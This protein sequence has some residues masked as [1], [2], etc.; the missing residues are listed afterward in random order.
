MNF[1]EEIRNYRSIS[2][3]GLAKNVGKTVTLNHL[4]RTSREAS[5]DVGV[6]SIGID[7]EGKDLVTGTSKPEIRIYRDMLFA[8][9]ETHYRMRRIQSEIIGITSYHTSLGR[10][11]TAK[12]LSDGKAM[13][14]G[15]ADTARLKDIIDRMGYQEG[16]KRTVLVDGA[17]SRMSLASPTVTEAMVLATGAALSPDIRQITARTADVCMLINLPKTE[18]PLSCIPV[19][20]GMWGMDHE[21][22]FH[23]LG[24]KSALKTGVTR[25]NIFRY[26]TTFYVSGI[27]TDH[28]IKYLLARKEIESV[29]LIVKDFTR[30]FAA[31]ALIRIFLAKG[32][33]ICV[34]YRSK[35]IAVTVNPYSPAGY[36]VDREKLVES[37]QEKLNV[38][39]TYINPES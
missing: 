30:I 38:P 23:D 31:P 20:E 32:G 11:V 10:V 35:L 2:V 21:G 37:L 5:L 1:A 24:L 16:I 25:T 13:L 28:L 8:T 39:V 6:T 26:G 19:S 22:K 36:S 17:L 3:V 9:S 15:P 12:A 4:L 18:Y 34:V 7:G 27:V 33:R 14:S 29:Q